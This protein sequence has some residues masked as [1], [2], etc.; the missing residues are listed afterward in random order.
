MD[1]TRLPLTHRQTIPEDYLDLLGHM[2]VMWYTHLFDMATWNFVALFGMTPDYHLHS[3]NGSFALE[4]HTRYLAEVRAG[5]NVLIYTRLLG[6]SAKRFHFFHFMVKEKSG[7]L[8]ATTELIGTHVDMGT[9]RTSPLPGEIGAL[10]DRMLAEH[11]A[12]GWEA[13]VCGAMAP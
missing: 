7:L 4:Q 5:E 12:L 6:R 3:G 9:R 8:S 13:P 11:Q 2:N 10:V 1:F